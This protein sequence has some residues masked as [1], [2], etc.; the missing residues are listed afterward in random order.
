VVQLKIDLKDAVESL[1]RSKRMASFCFSGAGAYLDTDD[2]ARAAGASIVTVL[3]KHG[4]APPYVLA[5]KDLTDKVVPWVAKALE[6]DD[7]TS[8]SRVTQLLKAFS[9]HGKLFRCTL[10]RITNIFQG[11]LEDI[12][13]VS[14]RVSPSSVVSAIVRWFDRDVPKAFSVAT[15]ALFTMVQPCK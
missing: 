9:H 11:R 4:T 1:L 12:M 10:L 6:A 5:G 2:L 15:A 8:F 7:L 14:H 3:V 13:S